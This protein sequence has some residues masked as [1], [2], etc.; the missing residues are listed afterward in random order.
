MLK[1]AHL[2]TLLSLCSVS[3]VACVGDLQDSAEDTG[4]ASE[5]EGVHWRQIFPDLSP[6]T[7]SC[8]DVVE[9]DCDWRSECVPEWGGRGRSEHTACGGVLLT[10]DAAQHAAT[11]DASGAVYCYRACMGLKN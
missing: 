9:G 4:A 8:M 2:A 10:C 1:P 3:A 11:G 6:C 7:G 5:P